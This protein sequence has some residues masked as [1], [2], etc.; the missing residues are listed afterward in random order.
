M[1]ICVYTSMYVLGFQS[2]YCMYVC[3]DSCG[4]P[5]RICRFRGDLPSALLFPRPHIRTLPAL[6]R[7]FRR[8]IVQDTTLISIA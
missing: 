7:H 8:M 3:D 5:P 6:V 1:Y 4:W 2:I